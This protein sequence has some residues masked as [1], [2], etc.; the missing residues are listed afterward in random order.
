M[1]VWTSA[2]ISGGHV[3]PAVS[4]HEPD[5]SGR[6]SYVPLKI[7]L[8][9][10]TWRGFPWRKV[11]GMF[12]QNTELISEVEYPILNTHFQH[13]YLPRLWEVS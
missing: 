4:V 5:T 6:N 8:A 2:G 13:I 12:I 3:N 9:L 10:A 7:T 1:G 11:P